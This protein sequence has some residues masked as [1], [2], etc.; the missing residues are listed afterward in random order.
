MQS[1]ILGFF[2]VH[3][4]VP[5]IAYLFKTFRS[6]VDVDALQWLSLECYCML[7]IC[8]FWITLGL[9]KTVGAQAA[10][11]LFINTTTKYSVLAVL[12]GALILATNRGMHLQNGV[13][14]LNDMLVLDNWVVWAQMGVLVLALVFVWFS[15]A[16]NFTR[17][18]YYFELLLFTL[19]A[20]FLML[21][22]VE[23]WNLIVFYL[24]L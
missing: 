2:N 24:L 15:A 12:V 13:Y 4:L 6:V 5:D 23:S 21:M 11:V 1:P 19:T 9:S 18:S 10:D 16:H 3:D 17:N 8:I 20:T 7:F 14:L 22:L